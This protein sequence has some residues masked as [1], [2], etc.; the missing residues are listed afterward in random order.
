MT[1]TPTIPDSTPILPTPLAPTVPPIADAAPDAVYRQGKKVARALRKFARSKGGW[2]PNI[3][4]EGEG[5]PFPRKPAWQFVAACYGCTPMISGTNEVQDEKNRELGYKAIA[6]L[7]NAQG[8]ILTA[9]DSEC[10]RTEQDWADKPSFQVLSMAQTRACGKV[11]ANLW[12]WV[13]ELAG[14]SPTPAEEIPGSYQQ[15]GRGPILTGKK[16]ADC[17]GQI[18]DTQ[19]RKSRQR[20]GK[21]LCTNHAKAED[22]ARGAQIVN[23]VNDP[24]FVEKSIAQ[25]RESVQQRKAAAAQPIVDLLDDEPEDE[26][27]AVNGWRDR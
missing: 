26:P 17:G 11:C 15:Q 2:N 25:V 6:H 4:W 20:F 27:Q 16:C 10:L 23:K 12:C 13:M 22:D 24:A 9:A 7:A 18:T 3:V 1:T 21:A 19:W 5:G 14:L 8:R